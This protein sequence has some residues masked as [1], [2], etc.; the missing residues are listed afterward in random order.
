LAAEDGKQSRPEGFS[1]CPKSVTLECTGRVPF[2]VNNNAGSEFDLRAGILLEKRN[3]KRPPV[4]AN[5]KAW[6]DLTLT[7]ICH[8]SLIF[9]F[10]TFQ[11]SQT[12]QL[13]I[14]D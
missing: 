9:A 12:I 14:S 8:I 11:N 5:L 4:L 3:V 1:G 2:E 10:A 13:N 6:T 7:F